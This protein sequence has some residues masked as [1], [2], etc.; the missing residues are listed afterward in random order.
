MTSHVGRLYALAG[1]LLGFFLVWALV[2]SHPWRSASGDP[3]LQALVQ[4]ERRLRADAALVRQVT[5]RRELE[6]RQA[7]AA[8]REL[9]VRRSRIAAGRTEIA[10]QQAAAA[11]AAVSAAAPAPQ[12]SVRVVTLPPLTITR[13]S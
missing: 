4:R 12:P 7:L 11:R 8:R 10:S 6:Y 13:T 2:A 3:R 9:A 1:A 5:A